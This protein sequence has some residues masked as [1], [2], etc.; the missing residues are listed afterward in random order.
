MRTYQTTPRPGTNT[1]VR[2]RSAPVVIGLLAATRL[3]TAPVEEYDAG[4]GPLAVGDDSPARFF[5]VKEHRP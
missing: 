2:M 1:T 3:V 5:R 4:L